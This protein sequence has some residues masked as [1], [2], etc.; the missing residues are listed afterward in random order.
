MRLSKPASRALFAQKTLMTNLA[1]VYPSSIN[2]AISSIDEIDVF[3]ELPDSFV[4][5]VVRI[6]KKID[7]RNPKKSIYAARKTLAEESGRSIES[8]HRCVR[9]LAEKGL[10]EREQ[11]ARTGLR[12]SSSPITPTD[13]L[14]DALMLSKAAQLKLPQ[15]P[16]MAPARPHAKQSEFVRFG[17]IA[18]PFDVAWLHI[19][20][21]L[22]LPMVLKLMKEAKLYGTRLSDVLLGCK[23]YIADMNG[24]HLFFYVLKV[25]KRGGNYIEKAAQHKQQQELKDVQKAAQS[26]VGIT[27]KSMKSGVLL[28]V[29]DCFA[30]ERITESGL[31]S[32]I[33][34]DKKFI[35][36]V[37]CGTL[38]IVEE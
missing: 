29:K 22:K 30:I 31:T 12:G 21:K 19:D 13:A 7:V 37:S 20:A 14:L 8:I 25:I 1:T 5:I 26:F 38:S 32:V 36:A 6:I 33:P 17:K 28:R 11:K 23:D 10:I 16:R 35:D 24:R 4:R 18:L 3:K 2:R 9:W 34:L 27:F 15:A